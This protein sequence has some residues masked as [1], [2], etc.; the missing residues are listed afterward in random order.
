MSEREV[1]YPFV[2]VLFFLIGESV[3]I[4]IFK[5]LVRF[6][7]GFFLDFLITDPI[8]LLLVELFMSELN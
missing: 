3:G 7:K 4:T 6:D 2:A 8:H 5:L 1:I